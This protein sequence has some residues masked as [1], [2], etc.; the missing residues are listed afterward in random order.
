MPRGTNGW[1]QVPV[2]ISAVPWQTSY[3]AIWVEEWVA[4]V[5][6]GMNF[7]IDMSPHNLLLSVLLDGPLRNAREAVVVNSCKGK[8]SPITEGERLLL[9][10]SDL[11]AP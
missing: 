9:D 10:A 4:I 8:S 5:Q 3:G 1:A 2:S 7:M 6:I 11:R